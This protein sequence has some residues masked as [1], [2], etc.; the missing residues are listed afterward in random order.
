MI[1]YLPRPPGNTHINRNGLII[2]TEGAGRMSQGAGRIEESNVR[3]TTIDGAIIGLHI[4]NDPA[5]HQLLLD[6]LQFELDPVLATGLYR[7]TSIFGVRY[8]NFGF[9]SYW[10]G[11]ANSPR[12]L[13]CY[14]TPWCLPGSLSV[15]ITL[16]IPGLG[17][18]DSQNREISETL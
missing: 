17:L 7:G 4:C 18:R 13:F 5:P 6:S 8:S 2:K 14:R 10:E 12:N 3:V 16:L 9:V 1:S 15:C 11:R